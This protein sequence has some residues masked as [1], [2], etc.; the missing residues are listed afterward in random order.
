MVS[1]QCFLLHDPCGN[2]A[3]PWDC[4]ADP[5]CAFAPTP[6]ARLGGQCVTLPQHDPC[7][8]LS[9]TMCAANPICR[10]A[11][12]CIT[13][14]C[15]DKADTCCGLSDA[16]CSSASSCV[17]KSDCWPAVD[18]CAPIANETLCAASDF[19]HWEEWEAPQQ[20]ISEELINGT[21]MPGTDF[22]SE[23]E[24]GVTHG[25]GANIH[26]NNRPPKRRLLQNHEPAAGT[27]NGNGRGGG[28]GGG[29]AGPGNATM[30]RTGMCVMNSAQHPCSSA[31][32]VK[33]CSS[34]V[35]LVGRPR[36]FSQVRQP[37]KHVQA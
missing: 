28:G 13:D 14:R 32:D 9:A 7:P 11:D 8:G 10:V 31:T 24:P 25:N 15:P 17:L 26:G 35:D 27:N 3:T 22:G 1:Q 36:C 19:C 16:A 33:T 6:D 2:K 37:N 20:L 5:T 34:M 18:E 12:R 23:S 29:M 4:L 21:V 30:M